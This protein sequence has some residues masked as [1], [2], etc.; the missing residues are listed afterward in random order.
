MSTKG[1][2]TGRKGWRRFLPLSRRL[3]ATKWLNDAARRLGVWLSPEWPEIEAVMRA[4]ESPQ[5]AA[6][7]ASEEQTMVAIK[8]FITEP[9]A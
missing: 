4:H 3:A 1:R 2:S 6:G 7:A 9:K 5:M 8:E